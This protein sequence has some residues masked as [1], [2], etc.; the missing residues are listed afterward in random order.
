MVL[1]SISHG[2]EICTILDALKQS[3]DK[4]MCNCNSGSEIDASNSDDN[5]SSVI[6]K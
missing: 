5:V 1:P 3:S 4:E 2:L 6:K